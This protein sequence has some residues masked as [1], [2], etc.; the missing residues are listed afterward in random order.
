MIYIDT[1][2]TG[3]NPH[4]D[5]VT[6]FQYRIDDTPTQLIQDPSRE[7]MHQLINDNLPVV[8]HNL[9]FDLAFIGY[10]PKSPDTF[11]DTLYLSRIV[12]FKEEKH[13]LDELARRVYGRDIYAEF[14]KKVM[15]RT[16]WAA[17]EL[18]PAQI[19]Y[20]TLDVDCLPAILDHLLKKFDKGLEGIYDFDK[21]SIIAG[22]SMQQHG[23]PILTQDAQEEHDKVDAQVH[24]LLKLLAPL[25]PN[26]PKQ[27]TTKLGIP[28]SGDRELAE[29]EAKGNTTAKLVREARGAI[30]Y[31]NF[32]A[33]LLRAPR[34]YGTLQ[35]AARSGRFTS[36]KEN[37]QN[38]PRDTK[39]FIGSTENVIVAADFA[40]L[41]LRTIAAITGDEIMVEL[42]IE[43]ADLH[44]Y[45]A[46]KLFGA[47]F[48]KRDRQ[49][50]KVFN[51]S[52][53]YGAGPSTIRKILLT[54]TGIALPEHEVKALKDTW[55]TT[56]SGIAAWQGQGST[57][58]QMGMFHR[59]PHGRPYISQMYT[60]HLSIEN[61]GAGAEVARIALHEILA[62]LPPEA[63][64]INF[65]H[66]SYV[67]ESPNDPAIYEEAARV[68]HD[69]MSYAWNRA[70]FDK[71][72]IPMPVEVGVAH[73]LRAADALED[74]VLVYT[75]NQ[76]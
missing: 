13:S 61:Q 73:N 38:L 19:A 20:A 8:G 22:L 43:G 41:E 15:Q 63:K 30:K 7:Q 68:M 28:S 48:T 67:V 65:I 21:K 16:N 34:Y 64:L 56:F 2:T 10:I 60:D 75:G 49:I 3:L 51:F 18:S 36:S 14:D 70:P 5:R 54:Q 23:L 59:T 33:K 55:Q 62:N 25:N 12:Y 9:S 66:D 74:C 72:G 46:E 31:R 4:Q 26:S 76:K 58:H 47:D 40:Q 1:E 37:I 35:P 44:D 11:H 52:T 6:L 17:A 42:F 39:R 50:A 57:R 71:R 69:A 53:L 32:L 45:A 27:V 24:R 29:L